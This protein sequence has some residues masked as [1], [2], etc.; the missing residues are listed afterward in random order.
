MRS[1]NTRQQKQHR[2]RTVVQ[3]LFLNASLGRFSSRPLFFFSLLF[4]IHGCSVEKAT[5]STDQTEEKRKEEERKRER[6]E[7]RRRKREIGD[8]GWEGGLIWF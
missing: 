1:L 6:E 5:T 3:F 2:T 8:G 4:R 7:R